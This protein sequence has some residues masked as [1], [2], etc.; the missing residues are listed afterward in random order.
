VS[1]V[2]DPDCLVP[3]C[4]RHVEVP[5]KAHS[6]ALL[7]CCDQD[8]C[9]PCCEKCPTCPTLRGRRKLH[10]FGREAQIATA[11]LLGQVDALRA[12]L[13]AARTFLPVLLA[14][15]PDQPD[16]VAAQEAGRAWMGEVAQ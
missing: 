2:V 16:L 4:D 12:R 1:L 11:S 10:D 6:Q 8:D 5:G 14:D 15:A 3:C 9:G 13:V 7:A